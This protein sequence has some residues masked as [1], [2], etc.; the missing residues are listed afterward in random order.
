MWAETKVPWLPLSL[1]GLE[2]GRLEKELLTKMTCTTLS[3]LLIRGPL[4]L[5]MKKEKNGANL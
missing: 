4:Y 3:R 2:G 1:V 5:M